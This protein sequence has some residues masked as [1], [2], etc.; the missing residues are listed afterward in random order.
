MQCFVT[1][2][3]PFVETHFEK[4]AMARPIR[5]EFPGAVY[6]ITSRGNA[7]QSIFNNTEDRIHFLFLLEQVVHRYNWQ[8]HAYCLMGNHFHLLLETLDPSLSSGMRQ[9]NGS[10]TQAYNRKYKTVGHLFQGRYK[11]ILIEKE[12]YLLELS[13]YIVLNPVRALIVSDPANYR[14]SSYAAT[15]GLT[16]MPP[17][18]NP[19]WILSHFS[20]NQN[21]ARSEYIQFVKSGIGLSDPWDNL[22][23]Q[24]LLGSDR[25][26]EN[27]RQS[28]T[29]NRLKTEI[30]KQQRFLNR[31]SLEMLFEQNTE[32]SKKQ[33]NNAIVKAVINHGY[34]QVEV[35]D[36]LA[37][38][39][40]T[41]SRLLKTKMSKLKT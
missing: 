29:K 24:C 22:K 21:A 12:A 34:S 28:L 7:K 16:E 41:V 11:S 10:Y 25:F 8:C 38:H 13:R 26:V 15:A 1:K 31:P 20:S 39:Y 32:T 17:F 35:A 33:R 36:H 14:W 30:P 40:S 2:R 4:S 18:L 3:Y 6:H 27:M 37:L 23:G 9:L 5:I 19:N